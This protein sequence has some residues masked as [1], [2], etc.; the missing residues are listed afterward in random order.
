MSNMSY[1]MFENT[2]RAIRQLNDAFYENEV[3]LKDMSWHE[4]DALESITE[5][6]E[7]LIDNISD[8]LNSMVEKG[9]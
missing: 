4:K 5:E 6:A 1:C 9:E 3:D 7:Q 2:Q 8:Y